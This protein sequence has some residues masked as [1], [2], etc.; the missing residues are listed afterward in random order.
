MSRVGI[1]LDDVDRARALVYRLLG[2]ALAG[3]P[4][5]ELLGRLVRLDGGESPIGAAL[6]ELAS[7]AAGCGA[8]LAPR[9]LVK[10]P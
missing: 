8:E 9:G 5:P 1:Q 3:P 7:R 4:S 6:R 10:P 2:H